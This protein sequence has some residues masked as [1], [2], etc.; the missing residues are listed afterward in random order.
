MARV[1][2]EIVADFP[3]LRRI[4]GWKA[5]CLVEGFCKC[6]KEE[7]LAVAESI[8]R[9]TDQSQAAAGVVLADAQKR[10][11]RIFVEEMLWE[12]GQL[13]VSQRTAKKPP[14]FYGSLRRRVEVGLAAVLPGSTVRSIKKEV[15]VTVTIGGWEMTHCL[16]FGTVHK[17]VAYLASLAMEKDTVAF[18]TGLTIMD[19]FHVGGEVVWNDLGPGDEEDLVALLVEMVGENTR[20]VADIVACG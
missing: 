16:E 10:K 19:C 6:E 3:L 17:D 2:R 7:Q 9:T 15:F 12:F 1:R 4:T 18:A 11:A 20:A 13:L 8:I 14:S 5:R